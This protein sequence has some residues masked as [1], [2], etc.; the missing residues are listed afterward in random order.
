MSPEAITSERVYVGLRRAVICGQYPPGTVLIVHLIAEGFGTS[1]S[2]VRDAMQRLIGEGLIAQHPGG[3]FQMPIMKEDDLRDLYVW[4]GQILRLAV[5]HR[6][7]PSI[8]I[9]M[10]STFSALDTEDTFAIADATTE[11]FNRLAAGSRN[12]EHATAI[13]RA[14]ERLYATRIHETAIKNRVD[15]L[16]AVWTA[17]VSGRESAIRDAIWAYHR[18]RLR[19]VVTLLNAANG[20]GSLH[21]SR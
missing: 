19:R 14:G 17:T 16:Q 9:D 15:E 6:S 1:I 12:A 21:T 20:I 2:P 18:R 8:S 3:G 10:S 4:H 11:F 7:S 13:E 5:K